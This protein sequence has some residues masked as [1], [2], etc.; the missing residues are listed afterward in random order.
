MIIVIDFK[1][2]GRVMMERVIKHSKQRDALLML[3]KKV[4]NHP[5]ADWLYQELRKEFPNMSLATVYR[6]LNLLVEQGD[7]VRLECNDTSERY[8]GNTD[9][10][11]HF[12]CNECSAIIDITLPEQYSLNELVK[13]KDALSIEDHSLF[14]YGLCQNCR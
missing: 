4:K 7:A 1:I 14:F 13:E 3:L 12:I 2:K 9:K 8:D 6:N 11:Y 10:H 5:T